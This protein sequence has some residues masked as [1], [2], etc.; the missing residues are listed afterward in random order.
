MAEAMTLQADLIE[1]MAQ[2]AFAGAAPDIEAPT[3]AAVGMLGQTKL[4]LHDLVDPD[5]DR[6]RLTKQIEELDKSM[7]TLQKRLENKQYVDKAPA[8][9]VAQSR[10]QLAEAQR[11]R[12]ALA[13]QLAAIG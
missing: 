12:D 5:A 3:D 2:V 13:Q 9:L 1:T 7:T 11:Q 6:I 10:E 4:Y 8:N